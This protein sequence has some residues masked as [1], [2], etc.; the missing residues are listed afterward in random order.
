MRII[1]EHEQP[2]CKYGRV[3]LCSIFYYDHIV[4]EKASDGWSFRVQRQTPILV[5]H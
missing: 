5:T 3:G 2:A 4:T 1:S